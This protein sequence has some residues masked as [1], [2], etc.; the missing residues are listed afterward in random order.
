MDRDMH[1]IL[2]SALLTSPAC[3]RG[4]RG[5]TRLQLAIGAAV[6]LAG[7]ACLALATGI[8]DFGNHNGYAQPAKVQAGPED[9]LA[10]LELF[11]G[12]DRPDV[13]LVLSGEQHGYLQP[14]G[15]SFP[16]YGGLTR[17]YNLFETLRGRGWPVVAFDVGDIPQKAAPQTM[18]KYTYAMMALDA[19][20]YT[21]VNVG[22]YEMNLPLSDALAHYSLNHP[23]P[24]V[25]SASLLGR[26]PD[27]PYNL[28][29]D[30]TLAKPEKAP[31]VGVFGLTG[32]SV[33]KKVRDP[34]VKFSAKTPDILAASL[35]Q[36]KKQ[37][38]DLVVLLY[39]GTS[40]EA[41]KC[42][43]FCHDAA[44]KNANF[45][46][47]DVI[48]CLSDQSEPGALPTMAGDTMVVQV[49]HKGKNVGVVGA[50]RR[51]GGPAP[52]ALKYQLVQLAPA[53]D[54][55][56][57]KDRDHKLMALME[58]YAKE[59]KDGNYLALYKQSLHPVQ[60][61]LPASKYIGSDKCKKCH[62]EAFKIWGDSDHAK[63]YATLEHA[64]HPSLRQ[65]D[66][67]CVGCHTVG[68]R[69]KTGFTDAKNTP[70]L[71][72]V[73]CE[74]CH[75]PASEHFLDTAN[76]KVHKLI[77]PYKYRGKAPE[78]AAAKNQRMIAIGDFCRK[79]HDDD[80][81]VH[82]DFDKTWPK[83]IHMTPPQN[84]PGNNVGQQIGAPNKQ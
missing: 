82:W 48:L 55:P 16:Q 9:V 67:E 72:N 56:P 17:R 37:G 6:T 63:A 65:F 18:L 27:G 25:V 78:T 61:A 52:F 54:T 66:G 2:P 33:E 24:Q 75:G 58:Q 79:C 70:H 71:L 40:T 51:N 29:T 28:V 23:T 68:F 62:P 60:M 42:A 59:V 69:Y 57:G 73:G 81:D 30:L 21:A 47:L 45:P 19:M 32:P 80:N 15:C 50:F 74:S 20:K 11:K 36:L 44:K 53:F 34:S 22:E 13:V 83:V 46:R 31:R 39:Q 76:E 14:C 35:T 5:F 12:W 84:P 1:A 7:L 64:K 3:G 41:A 43:E 38:A 77:N 10:K 26:Q 4:R 49:G 8:F